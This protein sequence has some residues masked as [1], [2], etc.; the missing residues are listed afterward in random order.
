MQAE[1]QKIRGEM[2]H[3]N[4]EKMISEDAQR[5]LEGKLTELRKEHTGL[6]SESD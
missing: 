3:L 6:Q 1:M 5:E 2:D 4:T